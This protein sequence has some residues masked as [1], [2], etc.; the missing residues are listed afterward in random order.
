MGLNLCSPAAAQAFG[1]ALNTPAPSTQQPNTSQPAN[2]S[3][4]QPKT[5]SVSWSTVKLTGGHFNFFIIVNG[6]DYFLQQVSTAYVQG[7]SEF[8]RLGVPASASTAILFWDIDAHEEDGSKMYATVSG[9]NV[10]VYEGWTSPGDSHN[11]DWTLH[12][13]IPF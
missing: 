5:A 6:R 11:V 8:V 10:L 1:Q 2:S 13:T 12:K 7:S 4:P 3:A 9:S